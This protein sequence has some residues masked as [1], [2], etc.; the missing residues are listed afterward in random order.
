MDS[1]DV[2]L[3]TFAV[4][5]RFRE[6]ALTPEEAVRGLVARLRDA[7]EPVHEVDV[8]R[9]E[10]PGTWMVVAR[11]VLVSVDAATAIAGLT[12]TLAEAGLHPDETWS[13]G[14]VA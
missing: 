8:E 10:G 13:S 9:E 14:Q 1:L 11:F 12:E 3:P 6:S 5:A 2:A 7:D 4:L